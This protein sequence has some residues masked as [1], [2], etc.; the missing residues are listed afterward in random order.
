MKKIQNKLEKIC[1]YLKKSNLCLSSSQNDGR[2]NS[3]L[4]EDEILKQIEKKFDI[5]VPMA[6]NWADF[7]IDNMPINIKVADKK[8]GQNIN[9]VQA[10]NRY[11]IFMFSVIT[12]A[13]L[14]VP[15][16]KKDKHMIHDILTSRSVVKT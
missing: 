5:D 8:T 3:I 2:I 6:R 4:N 11:L 14:F 9:I 15:L 10:V 13:L 1:K 7:Y 12:L 16:F